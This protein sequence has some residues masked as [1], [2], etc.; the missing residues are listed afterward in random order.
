MIM[1]EYIKELDSNL[2]YMRYE[3]KDD[4]YYIY[5][6]TK[7]KKFKHPNKNITTKSV[8]HRYDRLVDDIP[9][10]GKKVKLVI[11]VKVFAFYKL[12]GEKNQFV[13]TLDFVSENYKRSRRT[14]RL[15][16]YILDVSNLGSAISAEKTLKRNGVKISDTSINRMIKKKRVL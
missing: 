4:T 11:N 1:K 13:E 3:L 8:K 10:N 6:E 5:C 2:K 9:F 14:K 7:T 15:E 12:K 16:N